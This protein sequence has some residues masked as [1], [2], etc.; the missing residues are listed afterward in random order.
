MILKNIS[1]VKPNPNP[2]CKKSLQKELMLQKNKFLHELSGNFK[3]LLKSNILVT[4]IKVGLQNFVQV[5]ILK[6][7]VEQ[8]CFMTFTA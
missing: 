1:S 6:Q 4:C 5:L 3:L 2:I 7:I 8:D